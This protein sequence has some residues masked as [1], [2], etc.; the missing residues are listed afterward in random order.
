M[1]I[2]NTFFPTS[3]WDTENE[4]G[5]QT[6]QPIVYVKVKSGSEILLDRTSKRYRWIPAQSEDARK[7]G[8]DKYIIDALRQLEAWRSTN[9]ER[10]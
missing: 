5:T 9:D 10:S 2:D 8:E 7:N 1:F 3:E 4:K 6:V